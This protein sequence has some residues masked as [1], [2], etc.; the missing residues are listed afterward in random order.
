M[1]RMA[2]VVPYTLD[3]I[4]RRRMSGKIQSVAG[5]DDPA[6]DVEGGSRMKIIITIL[7]AVVIID[8]LIVYACCVVASRA[9]EAAKEIWNRRRNV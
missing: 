8:A 2:R 6:R 4:G 1:P 7:A 9:D 3:G 5:F